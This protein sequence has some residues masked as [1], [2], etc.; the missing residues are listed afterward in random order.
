MRASS[1][2]ARSCVY[3]ATRLRLDLADFSTSGEG[4]SVDVLIGSDYY[5]ELV[6]GSICRG[7]DGPTAIHTKLGWV[8]SGP[9]SH[10]EI[11]RCAVNLNVTHVLHTGIQS[12]NPD[13]LEGQL[14]AFWELEALGIRDEE[15]TLYDD[16]TGVVKFEDGRYKVPLPW[17][18]FHDP[19]PDNYQLSVNRLQGLLRRLK[20]DPAVLREYDAI[21]HDQLKSGIIEVVPAGEVPPKTTHYLPHHAVV[22][23]NKSTTK[24]RVVYDASAKRLNSPSL[25][26]CLLTGPKF[27]QLIFDRLLR[28][29]SYK[30]AITAD[31]EKAFL[32]VAV[33]EADRN[34]LRFIW[35]DDASKDSPDLII[36]RFTRIVFGVSSSPFLLNA[37]IRFHLEKYLETNES[38]VR[39]LLRSTYVDDIM[40]G[41]HTEDEA[42][43][44]YTESKRIFREGGFN[45]RKF[46][47]NSRR[48]QERINL[49]ERDNS[50]QQHEQ[51]YSEATL[52][53]SQTSKMG[54]HKVLGVPWNPESDQFLF[55]VTDLAR[56]ALDL[57]PTKRNLVS[58]IGKFYDPLGYLSPVVIRF[59]ILFQKLCQCRSDWDDVIH[60]S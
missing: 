53:V 29:R 44:L 15:K 9:S 35:V 56:L 7:I 28:F 49:Q 22:R 10:N 43:D 32:M 31:L 23:R 20:Q 34:V 54:E 42:F 58:L 27:N 51:T 16:F 25:N 48:L 45:L 13:T 12:E 46:L 55:D 4:L 11:S 18:E 41:G 26:D 6:T 17:R 39:G 1:G 19:L 24:V 2:T 38:L 60:D 36:Y 59:K 47:T 14:R 5:W 8:L 52:G 40:S 37:T 30:I 33:E 3:S 21:I 57:H 50:P